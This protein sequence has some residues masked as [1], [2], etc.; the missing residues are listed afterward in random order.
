[1]LVRTSGP[2]LEVAKSVR[3]AAHEVLPASPISASTTL[4]DQE[5]RT[6]SERRNT[7]LIATGSLSLVLLLT[8]IGL[9]GVVALAVEQRRREIGVRLAL[10]ARVGQVIG[11]FC[12]DG[13]R[14]GGVS[15]AIGLTLSFAGVAILNASL[16]R[17]PGTTEPSL[18]ALASIIVVLVMAI[19]FVATFLPA[20]RVS[21][22]DPMLA[23]R[24]E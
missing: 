24:S 1:M 13:L 16:S 12:A 4:A 7:W 20:R 22:V 2:A 10:G 15:L 17:A 14:I 11:M 19:S 3:R 8:S 6:R 21:K 18:W 23:L 5:E 9:F